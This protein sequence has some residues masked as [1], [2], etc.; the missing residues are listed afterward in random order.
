MIRRETLSQIYVSS[1]STNM[2]FPIDDI[3]FTGIVRE[4]IGVKLD[5]KREKFDNLCVHLSNQ[6]GEEHVVDGI[7]E[8]FAHDS[9]LQ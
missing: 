6:N 5:K 8:R 3:F 7:K 4:K 2:E 9:F 1:L